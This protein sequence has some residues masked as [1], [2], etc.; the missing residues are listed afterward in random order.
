MRKDAGVSSE[1]IP[2]HPVSVTVL[3]E[4]RL[5]YSFIRRLNVLADVI[6]QIMAEATVRKQALAC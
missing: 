5:G 4:V 3:V 1:T 6:T 2:H